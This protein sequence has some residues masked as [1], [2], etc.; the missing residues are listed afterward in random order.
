MYPAILWQCQR[1]TTYVSS[2]AYMNILACEMTNLDQGNKIPLK[3]LGISMV[4]S[5][6]PVMEYSFPIIHGYAFDD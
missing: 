1:L 6:L 5:S 3:H 4:N 2:Q